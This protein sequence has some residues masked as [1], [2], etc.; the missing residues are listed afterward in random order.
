M[1]VT[2][3]ILGSTDFNPMSDKDSGFAQG[4]TFWHTRTLI[5]AVQDQGC[6]KFKHYLRSCYFSQYEKSMSPLEMAREYRRT[7]NADLKFPIILCPWGEVVDGAHRVTKA[8]VEGREWVW[9][10][11]LKEMPKPDEEG[12]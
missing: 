1:S 10:Y 3:S 2:R 8:L 5:N 12:S 11:R 4:K 6:E 7:D 9:A